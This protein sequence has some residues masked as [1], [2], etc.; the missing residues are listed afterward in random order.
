[1]KIGRHSILVTAVLLLGPGVATALAQEESATKP[2]AVSHELDGRAECGMCHMS[3]MEGMPQAPADHEGRENSTCLW[4]HA[5]DAAMQTATP[6]AVP[7]ELE[8][9]DECGMC[10]SSGMEGMPQSPADHEGRP[11]DSCLLCHE[12]AE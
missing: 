5:G 7:H 12:V 10:H 8:G 9:R 6:P 1:M 4:C 11:N 3:G 2:P